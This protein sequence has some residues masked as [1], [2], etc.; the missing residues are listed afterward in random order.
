M[1]M[2]SGISFLQAFNLH[3]FQRN[4]VSLKMIL[5]AFSFPSYIGGQGSFFS[6]QAVINQT[7]KGHG[8][9]R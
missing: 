7:K 3:F 6:A 9:P 4:P 5:A 8:V 2:K 1:N